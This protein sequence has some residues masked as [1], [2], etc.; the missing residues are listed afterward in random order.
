MPEQLC[1]CVCVCVC[2]WEVSYA[3]YAGCECLVS[4]PVVCVAAST[5][6]TVH[7]HTHSKQ[8]V[9]VT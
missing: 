8:L 6:D 7:T 9:S 2:V 3:S 5:M 1:V 4:Q